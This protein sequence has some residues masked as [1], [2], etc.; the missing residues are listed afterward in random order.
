MFQINNTQ[1]S[2]QVIII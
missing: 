1:Y 2:R